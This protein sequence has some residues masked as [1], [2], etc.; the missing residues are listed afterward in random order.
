MQ[1]SIYAYFC[2]FAFISLYMIF[3]LY[4]RVIKNICIYIGLTMKDFV[5]D[6]D[7]GTT[8][9]SL[10]PVA[11]V[12]RAN[13]DVEK[14]AL[15]GRE[16][17]LEFLK[18]GKFIYIYIYIYRYRYGYVNMHVHIIYMYIHIYVYIQKIW[19]RLIYMRRI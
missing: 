3:Y 9:E 13:L 17:D 12:E 10:L 18:E 5:M 16:K 7:I 1:V 14:L 4:L 19:P 2:V 8:E 15:E 6:R 11:D